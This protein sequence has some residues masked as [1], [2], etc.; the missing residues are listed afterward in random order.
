MAPARAIPVGMCIWRNPEPW[1]M[2]Y[3]PVGVHSLGIYLHHSHPGTCLEHTAREDKGVRNDSTRRGF[4]NRALPTAGFE[5]STNQ[6]YGPRPCPLYSLRNSLVHLA[7]HRHPYKEVICGEAYPATLLNRDRGSFRTPCHT[8]L[9][10][11]LL[12]TS[13]AD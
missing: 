5:T 2:G 11:K 3:P 7:M 10:T 12:V 6:Q 4:I 9:L 8:K 1:L 13:I